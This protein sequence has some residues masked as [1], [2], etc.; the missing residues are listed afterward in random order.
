[1][2]KNSNLFLSISKHRE[3]PDVISTSKEWLHELKIKNYNE[4]EDLII[5]HQIKKRVPPVVKDHFVDD[6][7]E[8][9]SPTELAVRLDAYCNIRNKN[10]SFRKTLILWE[11]ISKS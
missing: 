11:G 7:S 8:W 2:L 1:M 10:P 5:A 6:W 9:V 4:L 3:A